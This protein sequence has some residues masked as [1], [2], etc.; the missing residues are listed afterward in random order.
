[1][2]EDERERTEEGG[3]GRKEDDRTTWGQLVIVGTREGEEFGREEG[4]RGRCQQ[5]PSGGREGKGGK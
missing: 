4:G 1:M 5:V 2:S 3:G